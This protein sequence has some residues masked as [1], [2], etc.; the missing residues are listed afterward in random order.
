MLLSHTSGYSDYAPQDY[1]IPA[2]TKPVD[3]MKLVREWA[4]KPLD[5]EPGTKWQ[6][7]NTNFVLAALIVEKVSGQPFW[8]FLKARVLEPLQ[9]REALNLDT[10]RLRVEPQGMERHALGPLRP[11]TLEAPGWY[12]GDAVLAMPVEDLL[13]WDISM[14][15]E[16]LLKPESY[17]AMETEMLLKNGAP[18]GYGLAVNVAVRNE[19]RVISHSGEVGGFVAANVV[20]PDDGIAVAVLTN[21]EASSAAGAIATAVRGIVEQPKTSNGTSPAEAQ[22]ASILNGLEE[23]KLDRSALTEDCRY[24]FSDETVSDFASSLKP[25]GRVIE[26]KQTREMLRGGMT[27]RMF[28]VS[29]ASKRANVSTYMMPDGKL[30]QFLLEAAE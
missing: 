9:M 27:M 30:E 29:F 4:T 18:T 23:G 16:T 8:N 7:S 25:L 10:D 15:R 2:W 22:V 11:A 14:I 13:R 3:P 17:K 24:Y 6:Y 28:A 12:F 21:Q 1:T 20:M 26:V 19:H 5:F